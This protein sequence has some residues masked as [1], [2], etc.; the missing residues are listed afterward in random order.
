MT[1]KP[2]SGIPALDEDINALLF[3]SD[4]KLKRA[5]ASGGIKEESFQDPEVQRAFAAVC[6]LFDERRSSRL[7]AN[8]SESYQETIDRARDK[9]KNA[10][11]DICNDM[12]TFDEIWQLA[13]SKSKYEE[14][15]DRA[16]NDV[17]RIVGKSAWQVQDDGVM[18]YRRILLYNQYDEVSLDSTM[19]V[20][21]MLFIMHRLIQE[22]SNDLR[23][24]N[25]HVPGEMKT[26]DFQK[27]Y[28]PIVK[29]HVL[30]IENKLTEV[31]NM[32][33]ELGY[34]FDS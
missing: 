8:V 34:N 31:K 29:E 16:Y 18:P 15:R 27:L 19:D 14:N 26:I 30:E 24:Y 32:L 3:I 13:N 1:E 12:Q 9:V 10:I 5:Y 25:H 6:V 23:L 2:T 21:T 33:E 17:F 28:G 7:L 22:T 20:K 4:E 11:P